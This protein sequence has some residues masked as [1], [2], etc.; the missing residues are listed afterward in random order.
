M[1]DY[2]NAASYDYH[3]NNDASASTMNPAEAY[4]PSPP[5]LTHYSMYDESSNIP[6][7]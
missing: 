2:C 1:F 7:G 3:E 6:Q 5:Y 4:Y